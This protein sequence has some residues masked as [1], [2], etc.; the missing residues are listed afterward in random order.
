MDQTAYGLRVTLPIAYDTAVER[1]ASTRGFVAPAR[2]GLSLR[3]EAEGIMRLAEVMSTPVWTIGMKEAAVSAW[4]LMRLY[5]T[6]HLVV[7]AP[8]G[9]ILGVVSASD[10]GGDR[11]ALLRSGHRVADLMTEGVV[12]A[13]PATTVRQAANLMQRHQ[14]D[15]LPVLEDGKLRG[16]VTARDLVELIRRGIE[17][18]V[19]RAE[20]PPLENRGSRPR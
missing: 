6:H 5:G 7:V 13:A 3:P 10:L 2:P 15:C 19:A 1:R 12:T 18:P 17:R 14:V 20:R 8:E 9:Q 16:I 4:E 11:G